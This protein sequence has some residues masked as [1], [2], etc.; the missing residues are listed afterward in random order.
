[1][2]LVVIGGVAAGLTAASRARRLDRD[3]KITVLEK[4]PMISYG[5]CGMPYW[6]EGRV[7]RQE[8]LVTYTPEFFR[9]E[10]KIDVLVDTPVTEI[11]HSRRR[12]RVETSDPHA[13]REI[14]YDRLIIATGSTPRE[15]PIPGANLPHC[16]HAHTW[17]H[18][19]RI[20]DFLLDQK[21]Q[22]AVVIGAGF[23]GLEMAE[24]LHSRGLA[25]TVVERGEHALRWQEDWI[26]KAVR[27]RLAEFR[28]PLH[29]GKEVRE[30][31]E[32]G[33][34]D[35]PAD[36]V[37][38]ATGTRPVTDLAA[39]AGI[40]LGKADAI[41]VDEHLQSSVTG[42]YAA[43][44]CAE[45]FHRVSNAAD[46]IPLGTTANKMGLIAGANAAGHRER[47]PGVVGTSIVRVCG[48]TVAT[49]GLSLK[50]AR[51]NG[52][53]PVSVCIESYSRPRYFDGVPIHVELVADRNTRRLLGAAVV[54]DKHVEGRV[55]VVATALSAGTVVDDFL[56]TDLCYAPPYATVWDPV[57]VAARQ[58]LHRLEER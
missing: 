17:N 7:D 42:I 35:I 41:A 19:G 49:T 43:G 5:A 47:F 53:Q 13:D 28:I 44:D 36:M 23:V 31:H 48:L 3:M 25:V 15:L 20:Q 38:L 40:R 58:L 45:T 18:F 34:D 22:S 55:N 51:Q 1:M 57:L 4:G 33:V 11:L 30:I 37:V 21:P 50:A 9:Q 16:F 8:D 14:A 10:R 26:T 39:K 29:T 54:G 52:F 46:W 27:D 6:I 12:V 32:R 56:F 24:A 2:H